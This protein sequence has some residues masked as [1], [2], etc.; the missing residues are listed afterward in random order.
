MSC[1][2]SMGVRIRVGFVRTVYQDGG[3]HLNGDVR[4]FFEGCMD[5]CC[6]LEEKV[7]FFVTL[8][9]LSRGTYSVQYCV[10]FDI[11]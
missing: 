3:L 4:F 2:M 9:G 10:C 6:T 8:K 5:F 11:Y 7:R 1:W